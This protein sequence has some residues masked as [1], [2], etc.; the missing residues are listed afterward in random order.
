MRRFASLMRPMR[1][2]ISLILL[3][4]CIGTLGYMLIENYTFLEAIYMITITVATVGYTEVHKLSDNGR[5]FTIFFIITN[6]GIFAYS[7]SSITSFF[8]SGEAVNILKDYRIKTKISKMKEHVIVCGYG[9]IGSQVCQE[10][11]DEQMPFIIIENNEKVIDLIRNRKDTLF[12]QGDA[13]KDEILVEANIHKAKALITTLPEDASNVFVAL[14]A[15]QLNPKLL[16]ISRASTESAFNK[17]RHAGCDHVILPERIG[18]TQ[19]A[20]VVM[21]PDTVEFIEILLSKDGASIFFEE[22]SADR[23]IPKMHKNTIREL[24]IRNE[25]GANIIGL[26]YANGEYCINPSPDQIIPEGSKIIILGTHE[27]MKIFSE[28]YHL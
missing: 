24:D 25:T 18:G 5:I 4:Y 21:R 2:P 13:T 8:I 12:L 23:I 1:L 26:K 28:K 17:L 3:Q 10:L 6:I 9:R 27:Q 7:I 19:M 11:R 20:S 16:I 15:R 22:I 14:S